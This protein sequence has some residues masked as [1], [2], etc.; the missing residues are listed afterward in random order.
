MTFHYG[1]SKLTICAK[2]TGADQ[3][4]WQSR[5]QGI[6][7]ASGVFFNDASIMYEVACEPRGNCDVDQRS[8][9]AYLGRWMAA[10][11]K[12][13]PWTHG[14][15]FPLL[16]SSATAAATS[17][18]GGDDGAT[19]G[20]KWTAGSWDGQAG[21]GEQM[22]G[23]EVI[24]STLID[25]VPGP[26]GNGTGGISKGNPAAGTTSSSIVPMEA[27]TTGDRAGAGILTA[28]LLVALVGGAWWLVS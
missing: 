4:M 22:S 12:V 23:L 3:N 16:Q 1:V 11:T 8:F 18:S 27:I 6:L 2:T 15:I 5:I 26:V 21:V 24:Q 25:S 9:K 19:C 14:Q 28:L 13:A 10:T 17:C 20:L 7:D